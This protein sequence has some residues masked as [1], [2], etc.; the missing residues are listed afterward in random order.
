MTTEI[1]TKHC[2]MFL[3]R[4]SLS[5]ITVYYNQYSLFDIELSGFAHRYGDGD[6]LMDLTDKQALKIV[7]VDIL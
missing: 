5:V 4:H 3:S 7:G 1:K 6:K 2:V